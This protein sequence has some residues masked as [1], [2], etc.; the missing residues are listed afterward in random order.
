MSASPLRGIDGVFKVG[1]TTELTYHEI[2]YTDSFSINA[3]VDV[4]EISKLNATAKEFIRGLGS[5]TLSASGTLIWDSSEQKDL[6]NQFMILSTTG[7]TTSVSTANLY[8]VGL[9]QQGTTV[10]TT[11]GG[12][13]LRNDVSIQ[14][15]VIPTGFS[16][17]ESAAGSP[18]WSYDGQ[19]TGNVRYVIK[20]CTDA[21]EKYDT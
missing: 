10:G 1:T 19:I 17:E 6:I 15:T 12:G 18:T 7:T 11:A 8:F 20:S 9:L 14:C 2:A 16:I 4:S 21:A 3:S 5:A 13:G